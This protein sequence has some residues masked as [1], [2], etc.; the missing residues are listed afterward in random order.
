[1]KLFYDSWVVSVIGFAKEKG[2]DGVVSRLRN[3]LMAGALP[4][5]AALL[6]VSCQPTA[7]EEQGAQAV[8]NLITQVPVETAIAQ[9]IEARAALENAIQ[10]TVEAE[11]AAQEA[12]LDPTP[13]PTQTPSP[14]QEPPQQLTDADAPDVADTEAGME[15]IKPAADPDVASRTPQ[16]RVTFS[17]INVRMGPGTNCRPISALLE[18]SVVPVKS[19]NQDGKWFEI[20]L[21]HGQD[22]WVADSVTE[23]VVADDMAQIEVKNVPYCAPPPTATPTSTPIPTIT[24]TA[25]NMPTSTSTVPSNTPKPTKKATT[26][27]Y[28]PTPSSTA[29]TPADTPTPTNTATATEPPVLIAP[30]AAAIAPDAL[31]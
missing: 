24:S 1:M 31:N 16:L 25:T 14:T 8:E 11:L 12:A 6:L 9:T 29:T 19:V 10:Q 22:G 28:T 15:A 5:A 3:V 13:T 2:M 17:S 4:L 21:P 20:T 18:D 27:A 26:P 23:L 7:E 30:S